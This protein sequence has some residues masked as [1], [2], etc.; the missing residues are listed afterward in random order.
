MDR[1]PVR[2]WRIAACLILGAT[3]VGIVGS[4]ASAGASR[5]R[6]ASIYVV[7]AGDTLWSIAARVVGPAGD[8][9]PVVDRLVTENH[10]RGALVTPGQR[11]TLPG[12]Q[13]P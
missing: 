10:I 13:G 1:T 12:G 2:L 11:L 5:S 9:R 6:P 4:R 3:L 8:P 7:K